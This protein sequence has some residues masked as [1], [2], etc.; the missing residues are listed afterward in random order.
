[1]VEE[2]EGITSVS[3]RRAAEFGLR[4]PGALRRNHWQRSTTMACSVAVVVRR[5]DQRAL[6]RILIHHTCNVDLSSHIFVKSN[7]TPLDDVLVCN[8]PRAQLAPPRKCP[9][10]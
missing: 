2:V 5:R 1:M 8:L 4:W 6:L 10:G 7:R 3:A 9:E